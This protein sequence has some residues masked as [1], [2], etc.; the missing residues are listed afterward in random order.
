M[1]IM[2]LT[3]IFYTKRQIEIQNLIKILGLFKYGAHKPC[4][5]KKHDIANYSDY[6]KKYCVFF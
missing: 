1:P 2:L 3:R 6:E 4:V 5:Y